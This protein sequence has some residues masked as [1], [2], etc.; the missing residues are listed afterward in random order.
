M[1][2]ADRLDLSLLTGRFRGAFFPIRAQTMT[3]PKQAIMIVHNECP[4]SAKSKTLIFSAVR[5]LGSFRLHD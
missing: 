1:P 2:V 4:I 3:P 5:V